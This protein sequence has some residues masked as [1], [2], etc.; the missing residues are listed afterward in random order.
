[1]LTKTAL[2]LRVMLRYNTGPYLE[3]KNKIK[4]ASNSQYIESRLSSPTSMYATRSYRS[5]GRDGQGWSR[6]VNNGA[7]R[8][9]KALNTPSPIESTSF[10]PALGRFSSTNSIGSLANPNA[11]LSFLN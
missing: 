8:P 10:Q 5:S 9:L 2:L 7:Q 11:D 3:K 1:M 6:D 4:A